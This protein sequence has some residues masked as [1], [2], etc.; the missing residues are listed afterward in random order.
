[1][2][3]LQQ[4]GMGLVTAALAVALAGCSDDTDSPSDPGAA[5]AAIRVQCERQ[6]SPARS[7]ISVDGNDLIPQNGAFRARVTAAGGSVTSPT[8]QPAGDEVEFDFDSN[9][10]DIAEGATAILPT[11]IAARAGADVVGELLNS[12]GQVVA[13]QGVECQFP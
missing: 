7:K 1:M 5:Q 2:H 12:Q 10:N 11:L 13:S 4:T 3:M 8:R 9:P 6:A